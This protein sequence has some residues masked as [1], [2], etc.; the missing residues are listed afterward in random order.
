[1]QGGK[2]A[3]IQFVIKFSFRE[4]CFPRI[5]YAQFPVEF[6][7]FVF[8]RKESVRPDA[9]KIPVLRF[10]Y[11]HVIFNGFR[12]NLRIYNFPLLYM[13]AYTQANE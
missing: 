7:R 11:A 3:I 12:L 9:C 4:E 13:H 5:V 10:Y 6:H 2:K 8:L 1:M